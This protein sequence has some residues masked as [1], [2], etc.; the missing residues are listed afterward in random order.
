[1]L[2]NNDARHKMNPVSNGGS[3]DAD[4]GKNSAT[5]CC[6]LLQP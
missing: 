4:Y 3:T 6:R 1:M 2:L 5:N